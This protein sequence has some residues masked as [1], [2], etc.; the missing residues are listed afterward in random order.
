M[1]GPELNLDNA[2]VAHLIGA[3]L[4]PLVREFLD[5][6]GDGTGTTDMAGG[7]DE[8]FRKPDTGE[9]WVIHSL[10]IIISDNGD[11][12]PDEFAAMG[13][14]LG[15]GFLLKVKHSNAD[16]TGESDLV[17]LLAG[18]QITTNN[19]LHYVGDLEFTIDTSESLLKVTLDFQKK[20]GFNLRLNP[21]D[22]ISLETQ[23]DMSSLV[24]MFCII[25]GLRFK[26]R[27]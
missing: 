18:V 25:N 17:D 26:S 5:S 23:D 4:A 3:N 21:G 22:Y 6:D 9:V 13:A 1:I 8:Y 7:A 2:E 11:I 10:E 20:F 14:A 27:N 15:T 24:G 19:Q 16:G 12:P